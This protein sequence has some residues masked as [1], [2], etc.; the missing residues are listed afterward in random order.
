MIRN[1]RME[2]K[3]GAASMSGGPSF[4]NAPSP[5]RLRA[6]VVGDEDEVGQ[7]S[8]EDWID[9]DPAEAKTSTESGMICAIQLLAQI[10][11]VSSISRRGRLD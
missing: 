8:L 7:N 6:G 10:R 1:R 11:D 4:A 2:K 5:A 3:R 9:A